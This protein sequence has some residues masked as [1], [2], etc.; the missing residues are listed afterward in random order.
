M[1]KASDIY[2]TCVMRSGQTLDC[3]EWVMKT[4]RKWTA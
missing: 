3:H 4:W 2:A 1:E